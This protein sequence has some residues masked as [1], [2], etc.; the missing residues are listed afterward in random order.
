[1]LTH[2]PIVLNIENKGPFLPFPIDPFEILTNLLN[3]ITHSTVS[4][5]KQAKQKKFKSVPHG[6]QFHWP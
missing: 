2:N 6:Q 3:R 5:L 4:S 1:M